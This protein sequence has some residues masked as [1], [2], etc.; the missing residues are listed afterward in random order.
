[1][2]KGL[3]RLWGKGDAPR[4]PGLDPA[5]AASLASA[6][7]EPGPPVQP[8]PVDPLQ[9]ALVAFDQEVA[10][11]GAEASV[12]AMRELLLRAPTDPR[13][14]RRAASVLRALGDEALATSFDQAAATSQGQPLLE[15]SW[16]FLEMDDALLALALADGALARERG[17]RQ[18]VLA[19]AEALARL[20]L[21]RRALSRL[22]TVSL[23]EDSALAVRTAISS[24]LA[25]DLERF[26][27]VASALPESHEWLVGAAERAANHPPTH[28]A[29][30]DGEDAPQARS[31]AR[32]CA[33]GCSSTS[34]A[35]SSSTTPARARSWTR[36]GSRAGS[37]RWP[38]WP[39]PRSTPRR[40]RPGCRRAAG[41]GALARLPP[42]GAGRAA[43]VGAAPAPAG[44]GGAGR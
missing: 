9:G 40:A 20:G 6:P 26:A 34:T 19:G 38:S 10:A 14:L 44:A 23:G 18:A 17:W 12:P 35:R 15:L 3:K 21:H 41:A 5:W 30:T 24:I 27:A 2:W 43:A 4:D 37:P 33:S 36:C 1:M 39:R 28:L 32:T 42:A 7:A 13:V 31:T 11:R 16:S 25:H 22:G 8:V 29:T